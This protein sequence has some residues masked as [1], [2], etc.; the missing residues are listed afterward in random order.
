M[1]LLFRY[2]QKPRTGVNMSRSAIKALDESLEKLRIAWLKCKKIQSD[3]DCDTADDIKMIQNRANT[4]I[5]Y[6]HLILSHSGYADDVQ[7]DL[8]TI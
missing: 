4:I 3:L 8:F 2:K 1:W 5:A 6:G 7:D